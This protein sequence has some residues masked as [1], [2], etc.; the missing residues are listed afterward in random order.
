MLILSDLAVF[1]IRIRHLQTVITRSYK[2]PTSGKTQ[3][4]SPPPGKNSL[5]KPGDAREIV[6]V[7][8]DT[9]L[10]GDSVCQLRDIVS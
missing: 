7:Q 8:C 9:C 3:I 5:Q 2:S 4:R 10:T 1:E 6:T